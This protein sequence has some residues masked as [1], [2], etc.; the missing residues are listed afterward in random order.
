MPANMAAGA[1]GINK[2]IPFTHCKLPSIHFESVPRIRSKANTYS[3][4]EKVVK[5]HL[6]F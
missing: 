3:Y 1:R 6:G 2:S 5:Y 4:A